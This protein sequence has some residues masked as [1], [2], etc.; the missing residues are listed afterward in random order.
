MVNSFFK[1]LIISVEL[2]EIQITNKI[3][4]EKDVFNAL[5]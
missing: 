4:I 2:I 5:K 3:F 1:N